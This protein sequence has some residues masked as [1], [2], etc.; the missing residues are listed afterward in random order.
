MAIRAK[1]AQRP[2]ALAGPAL[3]LLCAAAAGPAAAGSIDLF[4]LT[5]LDYKITGTYSLALRMEEQ[6]QAL[7]NGPIDLQQVTLSTDPTACPTLPTPCIGSFGHT[8]LPTTILF[9]DGNRDFKKGALTTNRA[10]VYGETQLKLDWLN[11]GDIGIVASAAAHYDQVF[12]DVNDH[13]DPDTVNRMYLDQIRNENGYNR[14][15]PVNEWT[16]DAVD[17]NGTRYRMLERYAYGEWY[18]TDTMALALRAGNHLAAWG[19][20]LFFPGIASAQGPFDAT[21]ANI[22]GVEVKEIILPVKQISMQL[23]L[24]DTITALAYN[25]FEFKPTEIFPQGDF[26]SPADLIGPG[27]TFGYGSINPLHE[28]W[29]D[30]TSRVQVS[31]DPTMSGQGLCQAGALFENKPEYVFTA[32]TPDKLPGEA[33][34]WGV[35]LK[36]QVIPDLNIGGYYLHYNNH[37]PYVQLNMGYAFVG[38]VAGSCGGAPNSNPDSPSCEPVTT[39]QFNV[40]VPVTYTVGYADDIEMRALSF[41]TVFWVFNIGG[42][43]IQRLNVDTSL[44]ATISGVVAPVHTRGDTTTAQM[45]F[46]YVNNPDFLMYDEVVVVGEIGYTMV[47]RV[48]PQRNQDGICFSGTDDTPADASG[49][50]APGKPDEEYVLSGSQLFYDR[51]S[52]AF[53]TLILPKGRNVFPGWDIGTPITVAWLVDGTPSTPGVFGALY[54]EGDQRLSVGVTA[55]FVQNLEFALNYN[56]FFGDTEKH[57]GN[58]TLKANPYVDHDY[59]ALSIKYNL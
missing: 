7:I 11:L 12:H 26:F 2:R 51:D 6:D 50:C 49:D 37:N 48:D 8:G 10:A 39:Q 5:T 9:D 59:L 30:D 25:Q 33:D 56:A 57:I 29:C 38:D 36:M 4:G 53:Q 15:G 18:L 55:Q 20:S 17:T 47:D 40:R 19:E 35:G 31:N 16:Q 32:R 43:I 34:Q 28:R 41:S 58:S 52:W 23:A 27:G 45:S 21:K 22:P 42:E 46:L 13:D 44:E 1:G 14:V 24:T 3:G 54:G